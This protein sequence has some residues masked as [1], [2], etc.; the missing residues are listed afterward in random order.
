MNWLDP[1]T[2][3]NFSAHD[4]LAMLRLGVACA[5]QNASLLLALGWALL[6][7][8]EFAPSI[9]AFES[10]A[11]R[12][13]GHSCVGLGEALLE[14]DRPHEALAAFDRAV[15]LSPH[16]S[17][18]HYGRARALAAVNGPAAGVEAALA[19]LADHPDDG[20][21]LVFAARGLLTAGRAGELLD[22]AGSALRL[23]PLS[24]AARHFEALALAALG[25]REAAAAIMDAARVQVTDVAPPDG[26]PD[27]GAFNAAIHAEI[28]ANRTLVPD[29]FGGSFSHGMQAENMLAGDPP[30]MLALAAA[31][32][33]KVEAYAATLP[34]QSDM[35][36]RVTIA[37]WGVV[38]GND[39]H[40]KQ[41]FH[42]GGWISGVYYVLA[43]AICADVRQKRGWL[44]VPTSGRRDDGDGRDWP[45]LDVEPRAGRLVLFPS[46]YA[47]RTTPM[48]VAAD[49]VSIAFDVKPA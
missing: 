13:A 30:A 40:Q 49:R 12:G 11:A 19:A 43:P 4:R 8:K 26:W 24:S 37:I 46:Y 23:R 2:A 29:P 28:L 16:A 31:I 7:S 21:L 27:A 35:P 47:H 18:P 10:A 45:V 48:G 3:A 14:A 25:R 15:A 34:S 33:R 20:P 42:P 1:P 17:Q 38:L 36:A 5:P 44:K 41:H 32:K 6:A 39:G 22:I 9:V